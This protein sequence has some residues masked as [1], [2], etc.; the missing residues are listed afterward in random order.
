MT[1][2]FLFLVWFELVSKTAI[3]IGNSEST[4]SNFQ[5]NLVVLYKLRTEAS[6]YIKSTEYRYRPESNWGQPDRKA[7]HSNWQD[8]LL[9]VVR[10]QSRRWMWMVRYHSLH[11]L[12]ERRRTQ[13]VVLTGIRS[14][15]YRHRGSECGSS[16][17]YLLESTKSAISSPELEHIS[18]VFGGYFRGRFNCY[19]CRLFMTTKHAKSERHRS[20]RRHVMLLNVICMEASLYQSIGLTYNP[21]IVF[22]K[23]SSFPSL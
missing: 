19:I 22:W 23:L 5:Q 1:T 8:H 9:R 18:R 6:Q 3:N 20:K 4:S 12:D 7:G 16:P 11:L 14:G 17:S 2:A 15:W 21:L 10:Y 13:G